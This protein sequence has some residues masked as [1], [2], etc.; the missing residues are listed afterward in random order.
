MTALFP[1]VAAIL[2]DPE[3]PAKL[4]VITLDSLRIAGVSRVQRALAPRALLLA[5]DR[6]L[7]HIPLP[8]ERA[9]FLSGLGNGSLWL[10]GR[11]EFG[12]SLSAA[13]WNILIK[14]L[15]PTVIGC[16]EPMPCPL[17]A[18]GGI[19]GSL[20]SNSG[21]FLTTGATTLLPSGQHA[22]QCSH[23]SAKGRCNAHRTHLKKVTVVLTQR[24]A[25]SSSIVESMEPV[26]TACGFDFKPTFLALS[27]PAADHPIRRADG[28]VCLGGIHYFFAQPV[29]H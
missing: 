28:A 4:G 17:C 25:R 7:N 24:F 12:D 22:L 2:A 10:A 23:G 9:T 29:A 19:D 8:Q 3:R 18:Q 1:E 14:S 21:N 27:T 13:Q 15:L 5:T 20:R 6:V 26:C 16:K 11:S